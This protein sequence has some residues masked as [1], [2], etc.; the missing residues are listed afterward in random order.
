MGE[1]RS[2]E[3]SAGFKPG[4]AGSLRAAMCAHTAGQRPICW[5]ADRAGPG[6]PGEA[7]GWCRALQETGRPLDQSP[8]LAAGEPGLST[9]GEASHRGPGAPAGRAASSLPSLQAR[10]PPGVFPAGAAP[11]ARAAAPPPTSGRPPHLSLSS[12][13]S[14]QPRCGPTGEPAESEDAAAR[15]GAGGRA[16]T[17]LSAGSGR[18]EPQGAAPQPH[19]AAAQLCI[20]DWRE[21]GARQ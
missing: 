13:S 11:F 2:G 4:R 3:R 15:R 1:S 14:P 12:A 20:E 8:A 19:H 5:P 17:H 9:E 7:E 10:H 6:S 18:R 21:A 16:P